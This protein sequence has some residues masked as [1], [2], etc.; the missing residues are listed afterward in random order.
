MRVILV[1]LIP[2]IICSRLQTVSS[3]DF[4]ILQAGL[5]SVR[6]LQQHLQLKKRVI[7]ES[8]RALIDLV[9]GRSHILPSAKKVKSNT[10]FFFAIFTSQNCLY[11]KSLICFKQSLIH[12]FNLTVYVVK[13]KFNFFLEIDLHH[14]SWWLVCT[15]K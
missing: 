15:W 8:C 6:E 4:Y 14:T 9:E 13:S 1:A 10:F 12:Y 7:L 3:D 5:T 2:V 11:Q